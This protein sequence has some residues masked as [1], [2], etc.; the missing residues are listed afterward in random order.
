MARLFSWIRLPERVWRPV[1]WTAGA[2]SLMLGVLGLFLP[3][4]PTTPFVLLTAAC[5]MRASP[6]FYAWLQRHPTFGPVLRDWEQYR[7]VPRR[8][9][10]LSSIMMSLSLGILWWRLPQYPWLLAGVA[11]VC[12][13]VSVWL[14]RLPDAGEGHDYPHSE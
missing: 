13:S 2:L 12:V 5:W 1:L 7:A 4:L 11:L 6:R 14:W 10:W 8:A 9:K 3:V